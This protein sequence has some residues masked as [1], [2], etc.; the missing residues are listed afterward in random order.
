MSP[1]KT[2]QVA[3]KYAPVTE[4]LAPGLPFWSG[5]IFSLHVCLFSSKASATGKV[6]P[7]VCV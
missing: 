3:H 5:L 6:T 1:K 2:R 7:N 4:E